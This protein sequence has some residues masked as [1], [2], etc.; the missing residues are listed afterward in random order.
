MILTE[1]LERERYIS[2]RSLTFPTDR[3]YSI[4]INLYRVVL[5]RQSMFGSDVIGQ[6]L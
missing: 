5:R 2:D 1:S 6:L 3:L 4:V